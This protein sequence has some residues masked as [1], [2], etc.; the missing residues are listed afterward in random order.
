[1]INDSPLFSMVWI[2]GSKTYKF[3]VP[4]TYILQEE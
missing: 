4:P 3:S 1:M 2:I